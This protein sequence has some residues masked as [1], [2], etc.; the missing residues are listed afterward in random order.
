M[1]TPTRIQPVYAASHP[2]DARHRALGWRAQH[3]MVPIVLEGGSSLSPEKGLHNNEALVVPLRAYVTR[4][5]RSPPHQHPGSRR[6]RRQGQ[7]PKRMCRKAALGAAEGSSKFGIFLR[8]RVA[9]HLHLNST[10]SFDTYLQMPRQASLLTP[11]A[12]AASRRLLAARSH[13][14]NI[15]HADHTSSNNARAWPQRVDDYPSAALA[16]DEPGVTCL[17]TGFDQANGATKPTGLP[18]QGV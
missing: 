2:A 3:S 14:V 9:H 5:S 4:R 17:N 8:L 6:N 13:H 7:K 18:D 1:S 15:A 11:R 16:V 10:C 12:R